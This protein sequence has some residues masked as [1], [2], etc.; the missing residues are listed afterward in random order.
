[1]ATTNEVFL[2][3]VNDDANPHTLS[4]IRTLADNADALADARPVILAKFRRP[5]GQGGYF[6]DVYKGFDNYSAHRTAAKGSVPAGLI[7]SYARAERKGQGGNPAEGFDASYGDTGSNGKLRQWVPGINAASAGGSGPRWI[8]YDVDASDYD[9]LLASA[10][11]LNPNDT[12]L[13]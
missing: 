3:Y 2:V 1:M 10:E 5:D 8:G 11:A 6:T 4:T 12:P 13:T 7:F 9:S